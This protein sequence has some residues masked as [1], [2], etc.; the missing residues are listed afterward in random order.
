MKITK[1]QLKEMIREELQNITEGESGLDKLDVKLPGQ[2]QRYLNKAVDA[3][4]GANLNRRKQIAALAKVVD[5][6]G[7]DRKDLAK[8]MIKIKKE[9]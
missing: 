6:L 3:I 9:L 7:L 1:T 4:K 2:A 5:A 8:Y